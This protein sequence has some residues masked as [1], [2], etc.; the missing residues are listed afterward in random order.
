MALPDKGYSRH[1]K[2]LRQSL[3]PIA[4]SPEQPGIVA[5]LDHALEITKNVRRDVGRLRLMAKRYRERILDAAFL[6]HLTHDWRIVHRAEDGKTLKS[7]LLDNRL[8]ALCKLGGNTKNQDVVFLSEDELPELPKGWTWMPVAALAT[9]VVDGVHKKPKYVDKG[10]PFVTVRNLTTTSGI[11]FDGCNFITKADH[12][13]FIRRANPQRGDLLISKDGT[14]GVVRAIRTDVP[15]SLFVSVALIKPVD[16]EMTD[17]LESGLTAPTVQQQMVGVGTG[18]Q[19]IHLV[20]LR[21]DLVPIA[22]AEERA[23]IVKRLN[24][25]LES[26]AAIEARATRSERLLD[27]LERSLLSHVIRGVSKP[28]V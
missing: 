2:F 9:K 6:G 21:R 14:L 11:T 8:K 19:H 7:K 15:F 1:M 13:Q 26:I 25:L 22:P 18:L 4:P 16:Y 10:V 5:T 12:N 17:Y 28:V 20:D 24:I 3:F 23:E 27:R